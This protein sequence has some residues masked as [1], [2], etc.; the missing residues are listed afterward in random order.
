M[1]VNQPP[2]EED[3]SPAVASWELELT[4]E[5]NRLEQQVIA[6]LAAIQVATDL[7]DLKRRTEDL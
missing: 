7:A 5:I 2:L 3:T 6:L 1:P 4:N